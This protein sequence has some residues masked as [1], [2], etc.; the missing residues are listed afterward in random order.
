MPKKNTQTAFQK[1]NLFWTLGIIFIFFLLLGVATPLSGDDWTWASSIGLHRLSTG[2]IGYNGRIIS[3]VL[4]IIITRNIFIRVFLYASLSTG[5]VYLTTKIALYKS[6]IHIW[7]YFLT[8]GLYLTLS[9]EVYSQTFGWFA[10]FINYIL[11]MLP[12]FYFILWNIEHKN[13]HQKVSIYNSVILLLVGVTSS[14]IIENV[15]IYSIL[16]AITAIIYFFKKNKSQL[17]G[18]YAYTIGTLIGA[19]IMF[20]NPIYKTELTGNSNFRH[21]AFGAAMWTKV[22]QIYTSAMYKYVFQENGLII[23]II[24]ICLIICLWRKTSNVLNSIFKAILSLILISYAFFSA[25]IRNLLPIT[26]FDQMMVSYLLASFSILF[27]VALCLSLIYIGNTT[28]R[29]HLLFYILSALILSAPFAVISPYGP[30]CAFATICF[31]ILAALKLFNYVTSFSSELINISRSLS[32]VFG[33]FSML[34]ILIIMSTNGYINQERA[35]KINTQ[36]AKNQKVIYVSRLPF[37]QYNW[38]TSPNITRFQHN[39]Y[40]KRMHIS[41]TNHKLVFVPFKDRNSKF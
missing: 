33:C 12:I 32:L 27:I 26:N 2:F 23:L 14:L 5:L 8:T 37:Q 29:W 28:I 22:S 21:V 25:F 41:I 40:M 11:G 1:N 39:M 15:T 30:R 35:K 6:T 4:E 24:S 9:T 7:P 20:S 16:L 18:I 13:N 19:I 17:L 36:L 10:G 31:M 34:F 38:D 3:N